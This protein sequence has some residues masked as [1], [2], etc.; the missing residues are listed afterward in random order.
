M[1]GWKTAVADSGGTTRVLSDA[2][3]ICRAAAGLQSRIL[4]LPRNRDCQAYPGGGGVRMIAPWIKASLGFSCLSRKLRAS[5]GCPDRC[6]GGSDTGGRKG[7]AGK[8]QVLWG[9]TGI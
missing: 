5:R 4:R 3:W 8:A 6:V 1:R 2:A 9:W 7:S